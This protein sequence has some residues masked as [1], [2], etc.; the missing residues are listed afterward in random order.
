[1]IDG[2]EGKRIEKEFTDR[3]RDL[4]EGLPL[5][6]VFKMILNHIQTLERWIIKLRRENKQLHERV[7]SRNPIL[8]VSKDVE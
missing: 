6:D 2:D 3:I 8:N 1:M 7:T 5:L 4:K